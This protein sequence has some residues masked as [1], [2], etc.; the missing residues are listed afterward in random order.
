MQETPYFLTRGDVRL[1]AVLHEPDTPSGR[2]LVLCHPLAEEK[3]WSHRTFVVLARELARAGY[4]VLRLD[5]MGN[6]DS[7]GE[8][9][10]SSVESGVADVR[11]GL[12]HLRGRPE[13]TSV[14]LLGLRFGA[15]IAALVAERFGDVDALVLWAPI[16]DGARYMQDLLRINIGTQ[17][18]VYREVRHDRTELV[19]LMRQGTFVNVDGYEMAFPLYSEVS[20]LRLDDSPKRHAGPCLVVQVD[21]KGA[22]PA[23]DLPRLAQSYGQ[24]TFVSAEEEP[25]WKEIQRSYLSGAPHLQQATLD[26]LTGLSRNA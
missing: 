23:A 14:S 21:R 13:I 15:T 9:S 20:A 3:L 22:R 1:F 19:E 8:F 11:A 12:D 2:A 18:A 5:L 10:D 7:D 6:G 16:L 17:T 4:T 26:W 24:G 25:F